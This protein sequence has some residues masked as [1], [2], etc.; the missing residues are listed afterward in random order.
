MKSAQLIS[1]LFFVSIFTANAQE[2]LGIRLDNYSGINGA[3]L[4]PAHHLTTPF[5]WDVNLIEGAQFF[6]NNYAFLRQTKLSDLLKYGGD[7]EFLSAP[8]VDD[9]NKLQDGTFV[10]DYYNDDNRRYANIM[11]SVMGPSFFVKINENHA[12]GLTT[13]GRFIANGR[14]VSNNL[15]YYVYD[16][17]PFFE[18]FSVDAFNIGAMSWSEAGLNYMYS[19]ETSNGRLGLG[20]TAKFLQGY[21]AAYFQSEEDFLLTKLPNDS[22]SSSPVIVNFGYT[23]SNLGDDFN[24][25]QNGVGAGLDLGLVY[26]IG[27]DEEGYRWKIGFSLLDIGF[28]RF[29]QAEQHRIITDA[30]SVL[31]T[32]AYNGFSGLSDLPET[33]QTFSEQL[34]GDPNASLQEE[35]FTM[36]L[37]SAFSLQLER[38]FSPSFY[39]SAAMVQGFKMGKFATTRGS[40]IALAPRFEKR[41]FGATLPVSLYNFQDVNV[42]LALRLGFITLGTDNLMS[43]V[44]AGEFTGTDAYF[45]IKI[46]PFNIGKSDKAP[47]S[48]GSKGS[49]KA[50][51]GKVKCYNF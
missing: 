40:L 51:K 8:D 3:L 29:N 17:R 19:K 42:G 18:E 2:Q 33:A 25:Q 9:E 44:N 50:G 26:A 28:I 15:S 22:L 30:A 46:N 35:G 24:L 43:M 16:T 27:N 32:T 10:V 21:E 6:D 36:F 48:G 38:G 45:A 39:V 14:G 4:N 37:P 31:Q 47:F 41:W 13:R 49:S 12:L 5:K 11:T 20:I 23:N 7:A 1:L 34:L